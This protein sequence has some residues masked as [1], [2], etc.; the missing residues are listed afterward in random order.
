MTN[1]CRST[2]RAYLLAI[3]AT[4]ASPVTSSSVTSSLQINVPTNLN[5]KGGYDHREALFGIPPYGGSIQQTIYAA[6]DNLCSG[7]I[8]RK[9]LHP[10]FILMVDRGDCSFV[11]KVRNAQHSGATAVIIADNT[12]Q[13]Q[14]QEKCESK[15]GDVCENEEPIMGNDGSGSDITIPSMLMFKQDADPVRAALRKGDAVRA[16]LAWSVP[17]PDDHVE[18]E[19]W[20]SPSDFTTAEINSQWI[21]AVMKLDSTATFTPHMFLYDGIKVACRNKD[22]NNVCDTL[23]TNEGR[24]CASDPEGDLYQGISGANVVEESLRRLCIWDLYGKENG[25]GLEYWDYLRQFGVC[26]NGSNF[27]KKDCV[28]GAMI[29]ANVDISTVDRCMYDSGGLKEPWV[30]TFLEQSLDLKE[31]KG[32]IVMPS[33]YVNDVPIRGA[34]DFDVLLKAVCAGYKDGTAP[35]V[36]LKCANC[37]DGEHECVVND[38]CPTNDDGGIE[39]NTFILSLLGIAGFFSLLVL[40]QHKRSQSQLRDQA[41]GIHAKYMKLE[42]GESCETAIEINDYDDSNEDETEFGYSKK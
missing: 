39:A 9:N 11:Q 38:F 20:T 29:R 32:I 22:G 42:K 4:L 24:Y 2:V 6:N 19:L 14:H 12:C 10:P 15:A 36:C 23:C 18:Y 41:Y 26:D 35:D 8:T 5:Q 17:N 31:K 30:N 21:D 13:C 16:E 33:A 40:I 25:V 3:T 37:L 1:Y 28:E 34:L 27:M 7:P